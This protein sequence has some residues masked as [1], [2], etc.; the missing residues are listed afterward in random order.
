MD[1]DPEAHST[2]HKPLDFFLQCH[3]WNQQTKHQ[4]ISSALKKQNQE[5]FKAVLL[6]FL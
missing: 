5:R 3:D 4:M 6:D 1:G 2:F